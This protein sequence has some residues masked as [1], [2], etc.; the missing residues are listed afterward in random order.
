MSADETRFA[1]ATDLLY[2]V[3]RDEAAKLCGVCVDTFDKH[4]R[5]NLR[6]KKI[7]R[8]VLVEAAS[9]QEWLAARKIT[10]AAPTPAVETRSRA[11]TA[12]SARGMEIA[13]RLEKRWLANRAKQ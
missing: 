4:V 12:M 13:A 1:P 7:G 8:R 3:S 9:L 5:P 2:V 10:E 6:T 11:S